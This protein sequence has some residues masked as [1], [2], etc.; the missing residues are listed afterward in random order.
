MDKAAATGLVFRDQV[1][2]DTAQVA[3]RR[4]AREVKL[5]PFVIGGEQPIRVQSMTATDTAD[6]ETSCGASPV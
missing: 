5:G 6:A 4:K 1:V 3:P 2:I